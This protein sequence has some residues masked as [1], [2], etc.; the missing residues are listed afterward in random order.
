M[1]TIINDNK[2]N[3]GEILYNITKNNNYIKNKI[4]ILALLEENKL[5][6]IIKDI[7]D[8]K[9]PVSGS[10]FLKQDKISG[11]DNFIYFLDSFITYVMHIINNYS[12]IDNVI[13]ECLSNKESTILLEK[14]YPYDDNNISR[15][16][17]NYK[18]MII[19]NFYYN[20]KE[21]ST[22]LSDKYNMLKLDLNNIDITNEDDIDKLINLLEELCFINKDNY[23]LL[24]LFT[25]VKEDNYDIYLSYHERLLDN[26][27]KNISFIKA[28]QLFKKNNIIYL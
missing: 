19:S 27:I 2:K 25:K 16:K 10:A 23:Y 17:Y 26:Y 9:I 5:D 28:Y 11:Y 18:L 24:S 20:L 8:S 6:N 15:I 14:I 12:I 21:F 7:T 13:I 22:E 1:Q 3:K 4:I